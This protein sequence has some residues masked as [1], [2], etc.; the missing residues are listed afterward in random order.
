MAHNCP[1]LWTM[2]AGGLLWVLSTHTH[3]LLRTGPLH[4]TA[5]FLALLLSRMKA[6]KSLISLE[7]F[8]G[9]SEEDMVK[10]VEKVLPLLSPLCQVR[11]PFFCSED[12]K[13][14]DTHCAGVQ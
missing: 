13:H 14:H 9:L 1:G 8:K 3:S 5:F 4:R 11:I 10:E 6:M 12:L 2:K 7:E